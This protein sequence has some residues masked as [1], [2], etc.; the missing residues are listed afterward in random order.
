MKPFITDDFLLE[1]ESAARLYHERAEKQPIL[2]Y[3]CHLSPREIAEDRRFENMAQIW[4]A[5]DHYKWRGM[6]H[7]GVDEHFI[8]GDA[9]D[10]EKFEAWANFLPHALRN[11]LFHWS[12]LE[13]NR[14]FGVKKFLNSETAPEI[15][16]ECNE[17]L[18][19][20]EFSARGIMRQM[21]V[22]A[23]GTTDDPADSLEYHAK[24]RDDFE[25]G[26]FSIRVLPSFR[27][28]KAF[29]RAC[30]TPDGVAAY[31]SYLTKLGQA[32]DV[33]IR[34]F[35][36]L[37]ESLKKRFDAFCALGCRSTD[38]GF[39][40]F[41]WS[42]PSD[43]PGGEAAL[44]AAFAKILAGETVSEEAAL[45][46]SSTLLSDVGRFN[47]E[48][49]TVLQLH[50][51]AMRNNS[52]RRFRALGPDCGCDSMVDGD[53]AKALSRFMD[54][55]D[56]VEALPKTILYNLNPAASWMLASLGMNFAGGFGR[57][58]YGPGWWFLD[59]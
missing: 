29:P 49:D 51:G 11:P 54:S 22:Q 47:A 24:L 40:L 46:L 35:A 20:P 25:T 39:E 1:T 57:I 18:A 55:L 10:W 12:M 16:E 15:W 41:Q 3:H 59:Q 26:A 44:E 4:L 53:Y 23:V 9:G 50:I 58:Q 34:S 37:R 14:P 36:A 2:D 8:T 33:D 56:A 17:K 6:R 43:F 5:G 13:L 28:D 31:R 38:C 27:P 19:T 48:R 21:N 32:A 52:T 7:I 30:A 45:A 42:A